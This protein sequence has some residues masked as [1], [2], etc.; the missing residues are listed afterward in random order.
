MLKIF[1]TM[2]YT[3][4]LQSYNAK[5]F[6]ENDAHCSEA[7]E[8][9][10]RLKT[11]AFREK[12]DCLSLSST[13]FLLDNLKPRAVFTGH[14]H[15]GCR[16][17]WSAY[18]LVEWTVASLSWRNTPQPSFL[19]LSV[20][21]EHLAVSKCLIPHEYTVIGIYIAGILLLVLWVGISCRRCCQL[22]KAHQH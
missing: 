22:R 2:K 6:R 20:S 1:L 10:S 7:D 21:P 8:A 4:S 16:T 19:L 18:S 15:F 9:P 12:W 14:S 17:E 13:K 3:L 11:Q 5:S